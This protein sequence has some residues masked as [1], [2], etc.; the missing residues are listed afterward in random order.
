MVR[1]KVTQWDSLPDDFPED[2]IFQADEVAC[3]RVTMKIVI[4][5]DPA[6]D[7][8]SSIACTPNWLR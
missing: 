2:R 8:F 7:L 3:F 5:D 6:G 4:G 1:L